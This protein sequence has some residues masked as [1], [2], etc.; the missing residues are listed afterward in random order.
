MENWPLPST[1]SER[2]KPLEVVG[3]SICLLVGA[4]P[5]VFAQAGGQ[6]VMEQVIVTATRREQPINEISRSV[7]TLDQKELALELAKSSNIANALG[8][9]VPGFGAPSHIDQLRTQTLRGREPLYL[10]D[11]IPLAFNGG[12]G[13]LQGPLVKFDTGLVSRVEV[14]YGPT[15]LYGAG[16]T[17]G[18]IQFFTYQAPEDKAVEFNLRQSV[19]VYPGVSKVLGRDSLS[20]RTGARVAGDLGKVDYLASL[21]YDSQN[22]VF[23]GNSDLANPVYYGYADDTSYFVKL[24][25]EPDEQQRIE[26]SYSLVDKEFEDR[27]FEVEITDDLFAIGVETDED[28]RFTY[29]GPYQPV[30]EKSLYSL[31]Y[32]HRD[33]LGNQLRLQYYGRKDEIIEPLVDFGFEL[34]GVSNYQN[35]K[36]D[37]SD[38]IRAQL[39]REI[40]DRL[41]VMFGSDYEQQTREA[42]A[43]VYDLGNR[44][45]EDRV[46]NQPVG[47]GLFLYPFEL[48]TL[49]LF[50]QF[51]YGFSNR[52][53]LSGGLRRE[54]AEFTI[55]PGL[56]L[57]DFAQ[58]TRQGGSGEDDG[59]AY[60]LGL[61]FDVNDSLTLFANYA[62]G[63]EIPSLSQVSNLVP[64]DE[65]LTSNRAIEPQIVDNFEFGLRGAMGAIR[66]T[67]AAYYSESEFGQNF[68]YDQQTGLG[69]YNRSPE[70][71]YGLEFTVD[72]QATEK[73]QIHSNFGII[74]AK[75]DPDGDGPG[76]YVHQS[77]L[78]VQPWKLTFAG[79][80]QLNQALSFNFLAL[81][82]GDR[83]EA[84]NDEI[85]VWEVRGYEVLD[86]GLDYKIGLGSFGVQITNVFDKAYLAPSSQSYSNNVF[87]APRVAGAPGRA[88]S[89]TLEFN[90]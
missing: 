19:T 67:A 58:I 66:Y 34:F 76:G 22:G 80:Y 86:L 44:D 43:F 49:G 14:L 79:D 1:H 33:V 5:S 28:R 32:E 70:R 47:N 64:P 23:D 31:S 18:V 51:D 41:T 77:G 38:G 65:P 2:L 11:G 81:V 90:I 59:I 78:D 46:I 55:G 62:E 61:T 4:S 35:V 52:L 54:D 75:F 48:K 87:F 21:S 82:I 53:R 42:D 16:G 89:L 3:L 10:I 9:R 30:D 36:T 12:A 57:F 60:N 29:V 17:G 40:T 13:F 83:D 45:P 6:G 8:A 73:L 63:F 72:W 7:I 74:T 56:R 88:L 37:K 15:S 24:G 25:F 68:L 50:V 69:S 20:W 27:N 85:D 71:N 26:F 39:S 84:L